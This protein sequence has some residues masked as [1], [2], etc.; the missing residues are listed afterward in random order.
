VLFSSVEIALADR[1]KGILSGGFL[2]SPVSGAIDVS[3]FLCT[4]F[5]SNA[6]IASFS[7][8]LALWC[9]DWRRWSP[10]RALAFALLVA[11][12]PIFAIDALWHELSKYFGD[13]IDFYILRA[14]GGGAVSEMLVQARGHIVWL[15]WFCLGILLAFLI[16]SAVIHL[17]SKWFR[18]PIWPMGRRSRIVL[19]C[20]FIAGSLAL[21][22][23]ATRKTQEMNRAV[24][25]FPASYAFYRVME[26]ATDWDRDGTGL[27]SVPPDPDPWKAEICSYALDLPGNGID[28]NGILGDLPRR[29]LLQ[30][31]EVPKAPMFRRRPH[32]VLLV[33]ESFRSDLLYRKVQGKEVTPHLNR[34]A[35]EGVAARWAYSHNA[36]TVGSLEAL[37]LGSFLHPPGPGSLVDDFNANGYQTACFSGQ[38]ESFGGI[39]KAVGFERVNHFYDARR[40][41]DRRSSIFTTPASL[42][43]PGV[44]VLERF[45]EFLEERKGAARPLFVYINLQDAH[46]PYHHYAIKPLL[47]KSPL[48]RS[49]IK[50]ENRKRV[51]QTYLNTVANVDAVVGEIMA[52]V[53]GALQGEVA[54]LAVADHGQ[55]LFDDGF[56]GHG[57]HLT[58]TQT[59]IPLIVKGFPARIEEPIGLDE[60]RGMIH[61]ALAFPREKDRRP[62]RIEVEGKRVFQYIGTVC[63]PARIGWVGRDER[64]TVDLQRSLERKDSGP[65]WRL[66]TDRDT[67][68]FRDLVHYWEAL[69]LLHLQSK[70]ED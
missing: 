57:H 39:E 65:W 59:R 68:T 38:D 62:V 49:E 35:A 1:T 31:A 3:L 41:I 16:T 25:R 26:Y 2:V 67:G 8:Q 54:L 37:F 47:T 13:A 60:I 43:L 24:R 7:L 29:A 61:R 55:S 51:F 48:S 12:G 50:P 30:R 4:I 32:F 23:G 53:E 64:W 44:V 56:L 66:G 14:I 6:A 46:F 9:A 45:R 42:T 15:I 11:F 5:L 34:L 20:G 27:F 10:P 69:Q 33:L 19:T 36:F 70:S 22:A 63:R 17:F 52:L 21:T 40:D 28:E 18:I 58:D